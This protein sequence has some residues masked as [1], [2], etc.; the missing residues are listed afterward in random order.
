MTPH[1]SSKNPIEVLAQAQPKPIA[2]ELMARLLRA[3]PVA[4]DKVIALPSATAMRISTLS[5]HCRH[6]RWAWPALAATAAGL[7]AALL[8]F[9]LAQPAQPTRVTARPEVIVNRSREYL[10]AKEL[11]VGVGEDGQPYRVIDGRWLDCSQVSI[12]GRPGV[13]TTVTPGEGITRAPMPVY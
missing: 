13:W 11:A 8:L 9:K 12:K 4:P 3:Q 10:T 7:V 6:H 5:A 1:P 2:P